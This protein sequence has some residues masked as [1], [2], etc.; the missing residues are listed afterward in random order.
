M[1]YIIA[2]PNPG[3]TIDPT[4][5]PSPYSRLLQLNVVTENV[6]LSISQFLGGIELNPATCIPFVV[7][8]NSQLCFA[9]QGKVN[10]VT[11]SS[12]PVRAICFCFHFVLN[13]ESSVGVRGGQVNW[14]PVWGWSWGWD[15]GSVSTVRKAPGFDS[16]RRSLFSDGSTA[17]GRR[18]GRI[19][20]PCPFRRAPGISQGNL[21]DPNP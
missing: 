11:Y 10:G 15:S 18:G 21:S 19:A 17:E 13:S 4:L 16:T 7:E 2:K 5:S 8:Y 6:Q 12:N 20:Q 1:N 14:D 3:T 9:A